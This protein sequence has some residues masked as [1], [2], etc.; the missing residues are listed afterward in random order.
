V[1]DGLVPAH[2]LEAEQVV[3]S[4]CVLNVDA[5][6][7]VAEILKPEDLYSPEN[8]QILAACYRLL[9]ASEPTDL[10]SV[11]AE[12]RR[13]N[14]LDSVGGTAG[15]VQRI[16]ATPAMC[17]YLRHAE[18]IAKLA[19]IRSVGTMCGR[20]QAES[21]GDI[22]DAQ[23]WLSD[24]ESR[25][26]EA[27]RLDEYHRTT[28]NIQDVVESETKVATIACSSD[29]E[30]NED[31]GV[32][33]GLVD[34]DRRIGRLKFGKKYALGGFP[35]AGKTSL[36][37]QVGLNVAKSGWGVAFAS[38]EMDRIELVQRAISIEAMV[39][40]RRCEEYSF[41]ANPGAVESYDR[42]DVW[43]PVTGAWK[44]LADLP[45]VIDDRAT[46]SIGSFRSWVRRTK[47]DLARRGV[48]LGMV[49]L[50]H[51]HKM[52][53]PTGMMDERGVAELS[54]ATTQIAKELGVV[55]LELHPFNRQTHDQKKPTLRS[56]KGSS[57]IEHDAY[58]LFAIDRED[59]QNMDRDTHNGKAEL[60]VL[61]MR[62]GGQTGS[63]WL[64]F[65]D[66]CTRFDNLASH[67]DGGYCDFAD[68]KPAWSRPRPGDID[69]GFAE[70]DSGG[71]DMAAGR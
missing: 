44:A 8:R 46:F 1:K 70:F 68:D 6:G 23:Q 29:K 25:V 45:I 40:N 12:L 16:N 28:V 67:S 31:R 15:L 71:R 35:G 30:S 10:V 42:E 60:L 65:T 55:I 20:I 37:E 48:Q 39:N 59:L 66:Y 21:Y 41:G 49:V 14:R 17:N 54:G 57:A 7:D 32:L 9:E 62:G 47:V 26:Y 38:L 63:V 2:S 58:G 64:K 4:T 18:T 27:A 11:T 69:D 33:T 50:D 5:L 36:A 19:R 53:S 22:G 13:T 52:Q 3:I 24:A 34:L 61:K 51:L 43:A 56:F